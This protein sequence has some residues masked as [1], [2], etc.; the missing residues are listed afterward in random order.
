MH[1]S[2]GQTNDFSAGDLRYE[3]PT[4]FAVDF[5]T[6]ELSMFASKTEIAVNIL[7]RRR[8]NHLFK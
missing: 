5:P 8:H 7:S 4:V 6:S 2:L 1:K 3:K